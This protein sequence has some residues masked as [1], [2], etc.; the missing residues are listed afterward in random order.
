VLDPAP[1]LQA[2][3]APHMAEREIDLVLAEHDQRLR[4]H[5]DFARWQQALERL[6]RVPARWSLEQGCLV[7][8]A[9]PDDERQRLELEQTLRG[10]IPWRKGP[11]RLAGVLI[12]T[13]WRSDWKWNRVAPHIQLRGG[14]VLDVGAGNG[15]F[16]WRLLAHG[17][18]EVVGCDPSV[19]FILQHQIIRHFAGRQSPVLLAL[20]LEDL[21]QALADFDVVCSMGVLYHRRRPR[22]H[23]LDLRRR[24]ATDGLLILETLIAPGDEPALL[25]TPDRYAGMRNVHGLPSV[26][27]LGEWLQA[28]GF[29]DVRCVDITPTTTHEQRSTA[30]MPYHSLAEAL[31]PVHPDRTREDLP[32]PARAVVLARAASTGRC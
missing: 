15:Y 20:R 7:A 11:L 29:A 12:D 25:E 14:R 32:A 13:E 17:A 5:G 6:P 1:S 24:L 8:G 2:V 16:G 30:W 19:L 9:A 22:E 10:F 23:L 28:S 4:Q 3:L 26:S 27:L 31:H 21:P 18:G